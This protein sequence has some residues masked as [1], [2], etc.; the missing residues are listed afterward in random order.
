MHVRV[1]AIGSKQ[2]EWVVSACAQYANR[3]PPNWRFEI[4]EVAQGKSGQND[5]Q[6]QGERLL[7]CLRTNETLVSLDERGKCMDSE[8]FAAFLDQQLAT[9]NDLSFAIGG[10]DGLDGAVLDRSAISLSLS[11]MTLPHGMARAV[12]VEQLYRAHTLHTGHPYHRA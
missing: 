3:L 6:S 9:G 8:A 10:A 11:A 7:A 1:L 4:V 2:P 12:L 5:R